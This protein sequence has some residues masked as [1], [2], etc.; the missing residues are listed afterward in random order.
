[1][2]K[3]TLLCQLPILGDGTQDPQVW[4]TAT[5]MVVV[6]VVVV[7]MM[8]MVMIMWKFEITLNKFN[9]TQKLSLWNKF[10]TEIK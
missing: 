8:M 4:V 6:V 7:M 2:T 5:N 10:F 1:M 9:C 3:P